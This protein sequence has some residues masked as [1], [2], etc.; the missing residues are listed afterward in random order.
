MESKR[1]N[2]APRSFY[3]DVIIRGLYYYLGKNGKDY[4]FDATFGQR[5][6]RQSGFVRSLVKVDD[7]EAY[8]QKHPEEKGLVQRHAPR[9]PSSKGER[10]ADGRTIDETL[11]D[12]ELPDFGLQI[13]RI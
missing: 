12:S 1:N 8:L 2:L 7:L 9:Q 4:V 11:E 10:T 3:Q 6:M 5:I 13:T